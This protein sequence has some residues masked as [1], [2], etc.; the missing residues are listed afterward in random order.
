MFCLCTNIQ[1]AHY[2]PV[3]VAFVN[4]KKCDE[5]F[6]LQFVNDITFK[7]MVDNIFTFVIVMLHNFT[8]EL[9]MGI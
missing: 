3:S 2:S 7:E 1:L 4:T 9:G 5:K 8:M 6:N